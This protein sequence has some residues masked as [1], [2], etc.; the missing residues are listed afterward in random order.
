MKANCIVLASVALLL[1]SVTLSAQD[2]AAPDWS[3]LTR[4][5]AHTPSATTPAISPQDLAT[6]LY[7]FADDSMMGRE[8]GDPG[9]VRGVEYIA[10]EARRI[11]LVPMGDSGTFFQLVNVVNRAFD[12]TSSLAAGKVVLTPWTEF[13]LR[14]QGP[15]ARSLDGAQV[16][17][18]GSIADSSLFIDPA[19][20]VG[21]LV[22][23]S[24]PGGF[25]GLRPVISYATAG[26]HFA[27]AAGLAF[28]NL[29]EIP[30]NFASFFRAPGQ[31][32]KSATSFPQTPA[33]IFLSRRGASALLGAS[34]DS[35]K[36][37]LLG[38]T[39][40]ASPRII[41]TPLRYPARNV[42]GLIRGS[43]PTLQ[44]EFVAIGA[45]N[46][47]I[48][49]STRP[50][51]HD[52][53]YVV[54]HLFRRQGADDRPPRLTPEQQAQV[55]TIVA[56]IRQA[57][58]ATARLDSIY[59]GADDDGSG[60]VSVL[61][62]AEYFA[63]QKVKP[64]RSLL[65]VW[66]VGEEEGLYGSQWFTDH[67]SVSRDSIV[68]QLNIDMIGRGDAGDEIG[69][70]KEGALIQGGADYLQLIGSRRLS[71]ELGDLVDAV[72]KA[73]S[74]PLS[75]D[76]SLDANGHPQ[77]IYCRSDHYEYARYGIPITFFTTGGHADYHQLTD[78]PQYID[79][80]KMSRVSRLVADVAE[81]VGDLD[82]RPVVNQ[83]KPDL[84][85]RCVQ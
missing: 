67:P 45:H 2:A 25:N 65:F 84:H 48:G 51:A 60:S 61:E 82:H 62:I 6:R 38:A 3:V 36:P 72:N 81:R 44:S 24:A 21:K 46:D 31:L 32:L 17:Y 10:S 58:P 77:R 15:G 69:K 35:A 7:I 30:A 43:D 57:N 85:G 33:L 75:V 55:N 12:S 16:I 29:D 41:E 13:V 18:G 70:T 53:I 27:G 28:V 78:E 63:A 4:S 23:I 80:D 76:Y 59:N 83:P 34:I 5:R 1:S 37:G 22:V 20:A 9:N 50:V 47:H 49:W 54:N 68:A 52:S 56:G 42:V 79:Y 66:H 64:K 74:R 11:G 71:T 26:R 73:E 39:V 19:A 40:T 14:D 8:L